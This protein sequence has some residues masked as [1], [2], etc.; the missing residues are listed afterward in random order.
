MTVLQQQGAAA[1]AAT[2]PLS[3][4]GTAKK[5]AALLAIADTLTARQDEWLAANAED[6]A[7]AKEA[8]MRPWLRQRRRGCVPPCWTV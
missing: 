3:T 7:A 1:K 6:V 4:A 8:G 5:N 2:Y